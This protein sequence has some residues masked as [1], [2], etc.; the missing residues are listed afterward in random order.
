VMPTT[1]Q[2]WAFWLESKRAALPQLGG[3]DADLQIPC[4]TDGSF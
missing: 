4:K 1:S 3:R 2:F